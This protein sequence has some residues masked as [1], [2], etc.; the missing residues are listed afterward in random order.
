M[1]TNPFAASVVSTSLLIFSL[2]PAP[3]LA[4]TPPAA[5][6]TVQVSA[7]AGNFVSLNF[8]NADIDQVIKAIGILSGR[9]FLIDPRVKGTLNIVSA[10]PMPRELTYQVL[11]SALRLQG[12]AA[13]EANGVTTILPEADAKFHGTPVEVVLSKGQ[14]AAS[15][16]ANKAGGDRLITQVFVLKNESALQLVPILRPLIASNN[17][18]AVNANNNTLVI[19]DYADNIARLTRVIEGVDRPQSDVVVIPVVHAS[20]VDLAATLNRLFGDGASGAGG[21][22]GAG[23][24][25]GDASQRFMAMAEHRTNHVLIRSGNASKIVGARQLLARLDIRG[26]NGNIHVVFLKNSEASKV[27]ET[28]RAVI[29][30]EAPPMAPSAPGSGFTNSAASLQTAPPAQG[31]S[32]GGVSPALGAAAPAQNGGGSI[33]QADVANNALIITAPEATYNNLRLVIDQIDRRRPQVFVEALIAE[34][35]V[36][37]LAE[38]GIQ[39]QTTGGVG[40]VGNPSVIGGTNFGGPGQNIIGAAINPLS[41]G[42]GLNLAVA[43]GTV[44]IGGVEILNLAM[45][46]RALETDAKANILST[47]N[48]MTLDNEEARIVVGQNVP[49]I[50]GQ[51]TNTGGGTTPANPFQ[52]IVRQDVGLTLRVRPQI[53]EGG[54]IKMQIAQEI[55]TLVGATL[56]NPTGPVTN[57]RSIDT[58]VMADDGSIIALGGLI[59]DVYEGGVE[60]IPFLG[61]IPYLGALFRYDS[62][63]RVRSNLI[64]FLRPEVMRDR[65]SYTNVTQTRYQHVVREQGRL[66]APTG[67]LRNEAALPLPVLPGVM[68]WGVPTSDGGL[69]NPAET[70][71]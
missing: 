12:F 10:S 17:T 40:S 7:D 50:T 64:V 57:K 18:I 13:I 43:A 46:A 25:G 59:Q 35:S 28:L 33:V 48:L 24:A 56:N 66:D 69:P 55:S 45:L 70:T 16:Q 60:K 34:V 32:T 67:L 30:G 19:T 26:A 54:T 63:K 42:R 27:A 41:L 21:V 22:V 31:L 47:P 9:N 6:S 15:R 51:Y 4:Q 20:A 3:L 37:R 58:T 44:T 71:R 65:D 61:D 53:S 29:S 11:L 68:P 62:R 2:A 5:P 39:W 1:N 49:F 38:L 8:V 52:T 14:A 23:A 36:E